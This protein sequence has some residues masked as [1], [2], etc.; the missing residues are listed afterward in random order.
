MAMLKHPEKII[1][2]Y[3]RPTR[4]S[5]GQWPTEQRRPNAVAADI[6]ENLRRKQSLEQQA[7]DAET[8]VSN[9]VD[10]RATAQKEAD[11]AR[12]ADLEQLQGLQKER[13][14]IEAILRRRAEEARR[15]ALAAARRAGQS[16]PILSDNGP[17]HSNGFLD[18]PVEGPVTSPFGP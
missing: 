9:M 11:N 10:L 17:I 7:E 14:R 12:R 1:F 6:P 3:S 18:Y 4:G 5:Y 13:N 16:G 8:Q 15:R 2:E